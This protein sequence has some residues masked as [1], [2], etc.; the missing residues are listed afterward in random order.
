MVIIA[1]AAMT[2]WLAPSIFQIA[3]TSPVVP[4][5]HY[6]SPSMFLSRWQDVLVVQDETKRKKEVMQNKIFA[7]D[8]VK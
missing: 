2:K 8:D 3:V 6:A 7:K 1:T 4:C 5:C